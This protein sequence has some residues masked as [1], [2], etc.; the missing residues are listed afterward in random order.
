MAKKFGEIVV[1]EGF[2]TQDEITYA[3]LKQEE[4]KME[5]GA[6]PLLLGQILID[7][8][9]LSIR[10]VIQVLQT[11]N[12]VILVC[13]KCSSQFNIV[14]KLPNQEYSCLICGAS[15][16][17]PRMAIGVTVTGEIQGEVVRK[18]KPKI[19]QHHKIGL[20]VLATFERE[21]EG[22]NLQDIP[23]HQARYV[24]QRKISSGTLSLIYEAFDNDLQRPIILKFLKNGLFA[25][26]SEQE[27]F[28]REFQNTAKVQHPYTIPVYDI[29]KSK[30]EL[31]YAMK[32]VQGE[33]LRQILNGL[34]NQAESYLKRYPSYRLL[35]IFLKICE[36]VA[37]AHSKHIIHHDIKPDNIL[38]G[39]FGEVV[40]IDWG[41]SH[42]FSSTYKTLHYQNRAEFVTLLEQAEK[43]KAEGQSAL[44]GT[45]A[46]MSPEQRASALDFIDHRSD[47]FSLGVVFYEILTL[48]LPL[49]YKN[50]KDA[51]QDLR[52]QE[53][54]PPRKLNRRIPRYLSQIGMKALEPSPLQRY[55]CVQEFA[56]LLKTYLSKKPFIHFH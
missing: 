36:S 8:G 22:E 32:Y 49:K 18:V 38:I 40:L 7:E 9:K 20:S 24:V 33:S 53:P 21:R 54:L 29:G 16:Q 37:F 50:L 42:N 4:I 5:G 3:L 6:G 51:L 27:R 14:H 56:S 46:Y 47:I 10:Q 1:E 26:Q 48:K 34:L 52:T 12:K 19:A 41:L 17:F 23:E 39:D 45:P 44:L 43:L 30:G 31:Y 15:L 35:D 55:T 2:L 11:Q 13:V 25:N 28:I